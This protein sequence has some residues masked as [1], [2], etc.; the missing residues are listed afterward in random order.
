[1]VAAGTDVGN[2]N[3][4]I[5][6]FGDLYV[7]RVVV[8]TPKDLPATD[9]D[10]YLNAASSLIL[11][12]LDSTYIGLLVQWERSIYSLVRGVDGWH[13]ERI[14]WVFLQSRGGIA[15]CHAQPPPGTLRTGYPA[16]ST[17]QDA[18]WW[19]AGGGSPEGTWNRAHKMYY[20]LKS[21][22]SEKV[23]L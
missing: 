9:V 13:P 17:G 11:P 8:P 7:V 3:L 20:H 5:E 21:I 12:H 1:M 2:P 16:G 22:V 4:I 6:G 18:V 19:V 14:G 23:R 15:V 10:D